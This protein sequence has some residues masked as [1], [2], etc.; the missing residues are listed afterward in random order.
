MSQSQHSKI[1]KVVL[2][3]SGGLDT[4][5]IVPWLKETYACEVIAFV[6]D[7]GQGA[8]ELEGIEQKAKQSGAS[9]CYIVDLK[10]KMLADVVVPAMQAGAHYE[11]DYLLGTA[12]ARPIIAQAQVELALEIGADAVSHGC[13]G[14]GNDQVRF[15][16]AYAALA[17]QLKVIAP[18]REWPYK[19][20]ED[21]LN[22]LAER[23]IPCAAS[24]D[25]M[26]SRDANLWHI[27][28][29]G[30]ELEDP[31][32]APTDKVWTLSQ[33]PQQAP[34]TAEQVSLKFVQG[35]LSA[36]NGR[37]GTLTSMLEELNQL[38]GRHGVGRIDIVENRLVGMK[39]RGCYETPG[40]TLWYVGL[41]GLEQLTMD[42]PSIQLR[43]YLSQQLAHL[44]YD[45]QWFT[46]VRTALCAAA[47]DLAKVLTGEVV[48]TLY[49]GQAVVSQRRSPQSLY[50]EAFATFE[51]DDVYNQKD[52][53]GFI[54]L[55]SLASR[56][57]A[58]HDQQRNPSKEGI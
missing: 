47:Q 48:L 33:S 44:L 40:G 55:H 14:K 28:H 25:K 15:E 16:G 32:Q 50:S 22:F 18:W 29:E 37:H 8:Q 46:P 21:L 35:S 20:R 11:G 34:D 10:E 56:I 45:G 42:R 57:R 13:T 41:Q 43:R 53:A 5:A 19:S 9:A 4:S 51:D 24:K 27:S 58:L 3:Y 17:P 6:A 1:E 54:R 7:V 31:W 26:Y 52:A 49:K 23:N 38:G 39:S 2:A 36:V 30:G 12:L